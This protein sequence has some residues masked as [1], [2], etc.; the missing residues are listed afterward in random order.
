MNNLLYFVPFSVRTLYNIH[1]IHLLQMN[2]CRLSP[3]CNTLMM[4]MIIIM[5]YDCVTFCAHDD[6]MESGYWILNTEHGIHVQ[7]EM[8]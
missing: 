2:A 3:S 7:D 6:K 8:V 4:T 1:H 5:Y